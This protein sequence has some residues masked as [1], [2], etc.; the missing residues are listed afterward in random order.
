MFPGSN[1]YEGGVV[2]Q[3]IDLAID[4]GGLGD[5][6][7]QI[8]LAIGEVQLENGGAGLFQ[9]L[10]TLQFTGRCNDLV[11]A[12]GDAVDELL[13]KAG[14]TS[15]DEPYKSRHDVGVLDGHM[16]KDPN[17]LLYRED[18]EILISR[19]LRLRRLTS[20][21]VNPRWETLELIAPPL[22]RRAKGGGKCHS[23]GQCHLLEAL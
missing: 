17:S 9:M 3:H 6:A 13:P 1:G 11:S 16:R 4:L 19:S 20:T 21:C 18:P 22:R 23:A 5:L 8:A 10:D 2:D 12:G 15:S 7:V 14:G